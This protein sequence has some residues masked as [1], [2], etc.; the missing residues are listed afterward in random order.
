MIKKQ[1]LHQQDI[2]DHIK[3]VLTLRKYGNSSKIFGIIFD[4]GRIHPTPHTGNDS[5]DYSNP[6]CT[7]HFAEVNSSF[8]VTNDQEGNHYFISPLLM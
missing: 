5:N 1:S 4:F 3:I 6:S 2:I 8:F 7:Q